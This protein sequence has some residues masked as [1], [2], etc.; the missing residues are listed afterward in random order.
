MDPLSGYAHCKKLTINPSSAGAQTNYVLQ[1]SIVE[2]TGTDGA[3]IVHLEDEA[4]NWPYDIRFTKADGTTLLD[5][6]RLEYDAADGTWY[7]EID[8]IAADVDTDIYIHY[9]DADATDASSG[10]NTFSF[11]DNFETHDFSRWTAAGPRWS[12]VTVPEEGTYSAAT[13]GV[14]GT[15]AD[16]SIQK[17]LSTGSVKI[18]FWMRHSST[19]YIF[20]GPRI[21]LD[22]AAV[23]IPLA[24]NAGYFRYFPGSWAT[25]PTSTAFSSAT[26]YLCEVILDFEQSKFRWKINGADKGSATLKDMSGNTL[27]TDRSIATIQFFGFDT[28]GPTGYIDQVCVQDYIYPEPAWSGEVIADIE[29]YGDSIMAGAGVTVPDDTHIYKTAAALGR[30]YT[31]HGVSSYGVADVASTA[32]L[33]NKT[34]AVDELYLF[35]GWPNDTLAYHEDDDGPDIFKSGLT[36]I[37][38]HVLIPD[39]AKVYAEDATLTGTWT[40][41]TMYTRS[42]KSVS[43]GSTATFSVSGT[44]VAIATTR[45][46]TNPGS[47]TVTIDSVDKGTI[48]M[49]PCINNAL[50]K[51]YCPQIHFFEDLG[52]GTHS[53]VLTAVS[54]GT[55]IAQVDWVAG[56]SEGAIPADWPTL[57]F[58]GQLKCIW[59]GY[60]YFTEAEAQAW[61][62]YIEDVYDIL[63]AYGFHIHF[64][65]LWNTVAGNSTNIQDDDY[66]HPTAAGH[67]AIS[68]EF[69]KKF[70]EGVSA[71]SIGAVTLSAA[72]T[73]E[74]EGEASAQIGAVGL[75]AAGTST[76]TGA[77]D[78]QIGAVVLSATSDEAPLAGF[79]SL[80]ARQI[81]GAHI[82][83]E[84][85]SVGVLNVTI[86][87]ISVAISGAVSV[88]GILSNLVN[89]LSLASSGILPIEG[90]LSK[91]LNDI[92]ISSNGV[93]TIVGNSSTIL[94]DFN[95][96]CNANNLIDCETSIGIDAITVG[97]SGTV[98]TS[99]LFDVVISDIGSISS[100]SVHIVG[101]ASGTIDDVVGSSIGNILING[102]LS[103]TI[104]DIYISSAGGSGLTGN[105][106]ISLDG[107]IIGSSGILPIIGNGSID[108]S[109]VVPSSSGVV[110]LVGEF[111]DTLD[112]VVVAGAG[113]SGLLGASNITVDAFTVESNGTIEIVGGANV[114]LSGISLGS[115]GTVSIVGSGTAVVD[116]INVDSNGTVSV[117]CSLDVVLSDIG[118]SSTIGSGISGATNI[119]IG[120]VALSG[121]GGVLTHGSLSNVL[122]DITVDTGGQVSISGTVNLELDGIS[123]VA[124]EAGST[125][126]TSDLT[127]ENIGVGSVASV[128]ITGALGVTL[129]NLMIT[130]GARALTRGSVYRMSDIDMAIVR[131]S[132]IDRAVIRRSSCA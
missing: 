35:Q 119:Q 34:I 124:S 3:G 22:N 32:G 112:N 83:G 89:D 67:T 20:Y 10:A 64:V 14:S 41:P 30:G 130:A 18:T 11:W 15:V 85:S 102:T 39:S 103:K 75:T 97:C 42:K 66:I 105:V 58:G 94:E 101:E 7:I 77:V 25:L 99:G 87:V 65:D 110:T 76:I 125:E 52:A 91:S 70:G 48:S 57:I 100:G 50:S 90:D 27:T 36:A 33:Y 72:G 123:V 4:L 53:I 132:D 129:A 126:G 38:A 13:T 1:L 106:D 86:D 114:S 68:A 63:R 17:T 61:N 54:N 74:V 46:V 69:V 104:D 47:F 24:M 117:E 122:D 93:L 81:G 71:I 96:S 127:L 28:A 45:L 78:A 109:S 120:D 128:A 12:I 111:N 31:N 80:L 73:V 131:G 60:S 92:S 98:S 59:P 82:A 88:T 23:V 16:R 84:A 8:S 43:N 107:I 37:A 118:I 44:T 121:S 55:T 116:S 108:L 62:G 40:D 19:S 6:Y 49:S 29:A 26:W 5:F 9:G 21:V 51:A 2:S 56:F 115:S 113:G 95:I 79:K